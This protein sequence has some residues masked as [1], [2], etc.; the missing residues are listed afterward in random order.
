MP[1]ETHHLQLGVGEDFAFVTPVDGAALCRVM[2]LHGE[3]AE[4][5]AGTWFNLL[6]VTALKMKRPKREFFKVFVLLSQHFKS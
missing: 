2:G 5:T 4:Q 3:S 6:V 1:R